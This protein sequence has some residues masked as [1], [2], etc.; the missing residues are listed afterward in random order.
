M[1]FK[2]WLLDNHCDLFWN[3]A[4]PTSNSGIC[5]KREKSRVGM[6]LLENG[7][8]SDDSSKYPTKMKDEFFRL[9]PSRSSMPPP[10]FGKS[11]ATAVQVIIKRQFGCGRTAGVQ[12]EIEDPLPSF[13]NV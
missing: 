11:H 6:S 5:V 8:A 9:V 4:S 10:I 13:N 12:D 2:Y 7:R 1:T 3:R